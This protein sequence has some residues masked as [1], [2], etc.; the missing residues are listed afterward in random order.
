MITSPSLLISTYNKTSKFSNFTL[1][2]TTPPVSNYLA[3]QRTTIPS[4]PSIYTAPY[5]SWHIVHLINVMKC[6]KWLPGSSIAKRCINKTWSFSGYSRTAMKA[7]VMDDSQYQPFY[8]GIRYGSLDSLVCGR[9]QLSIW[10]PFIV[11]QTFDAHLHGLWFSNATPKSNQHR[12]NARSQ[13]SI[14]HS[15][16]CQF[17]IASSSTKLIRS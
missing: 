12:L 6:R 15:Q 10:F 11:Q 9:S 13:T 17:I 2:I 16:Q 3:P 5:Q 1:C 4:T 7:C 14:F 8:H